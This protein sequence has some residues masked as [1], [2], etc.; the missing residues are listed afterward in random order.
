MLDIEYISELEQMENK[1]DAKDALAKYASQF[2]IQLKKTRAFDNMVKDLEEGLKALANEPMPEQNEGMTIHDM[3]ANIV[4]TGV[5]QEAKVESVV[6]NVVEVA[7][8]PVE[9][10]SEVKI[11]IEITGAISSDNKEELDKL[12]ELPKN[13]S[14]TLI[15][16][17]SNPG[18]CTLPWWI[19][20]WIRDNEN[21]KEAPNSFPHAYGVDT[22]YSL[23]YYIRRDG[24]VKVRETRNSSFITLK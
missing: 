24:F 20:E 9:T 14:P 15:K 3:V 8:D 22:L 21:W 6:D 17:G 12:F 5:A 4:E 23:I 10:A 16:L 2:G 1:K 13:F 19:Y 18:Y 7:I 11:G